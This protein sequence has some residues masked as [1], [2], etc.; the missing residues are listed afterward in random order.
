MDQKK[1]ELGPKLQSE[2]GWGGKISRW[3]KNNFAS[4]ILPI[5]AILVLVGGIYVYSRHGATP[6]SPTTS[7]ATSTISTSS[8]VSSA[9]PTSQIQ[10]EQK[11]AETAKKLKETQTGGPTS[12]LAQNTYTEIAQRGDSITTLARKALADYLNNHK[13]DFNLTAEHKIYCEDYIQN[14][15]G[16]YWLKIGQKLSFSSNLIK[17]AIQASESLTPSQLSNL[18]KYAK[19][20]P[21]LI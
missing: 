7:I 19:M 2:Q 21:S 12:S 4:V 20:V 9:T 14:R 11:T 13:I 10:K 1:K 5:I 15:T 3:L 18:S 17:E 8:T 16:T 6:S